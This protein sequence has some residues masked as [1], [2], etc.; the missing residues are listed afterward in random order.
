MKCNCEFELL[1]KME[2]G[3][4]HRQNKK[5][6]R[7]EYGNMLI[8]FG[9]KQ[10]NIF[11]R[12]ILN[13]TEEKAKDYLLPPTNKIVIQ[14]TNYLGSYTFS[15]DEFYQLRKLFIEADDVLKVEQELKAIFK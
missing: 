9:V 14:P 3:V 12:F 6:Y 10:F 8:L 13:M 5:M 2:N 11:K 4:I 1:S 7:V 15:L